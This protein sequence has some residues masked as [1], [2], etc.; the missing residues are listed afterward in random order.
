MSNWV[1]EGKEY[2][3]SDNLHVK[4][5]YKIIALQI[6]INWNGTLNWLENHLNIKIK[7]NLNR[8]QIE[9]H[10]ATARSSKGTFSKQT[11][12]WLKLVP[13]YVRP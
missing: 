12:I 10:L 4:P 2:F 3:D 7:L 8:F 9:L 11:F 6:F 1:S 13:L 5:E